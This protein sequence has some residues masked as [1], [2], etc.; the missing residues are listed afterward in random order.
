MDPAVVFSYAPMRRVTARPPPQRP[1][2]MQRQTRSQTSD[3]FRSRVRA[4]LV[5]LSRKY[6]VKP[7]EIA[8]RS[9]VH[10]AT[11][12]RM[13]DP[14]S[15]V[16]PTLDSVHAIASAFNEVMPT[17]DTGA[18]GFHEGDAVPYDAPDDA[19]ALLAPQNAN[20][21]VWTVRNRALE[22]AGYLPGDLVLLD[23]AAAARPGDVVMAQIYD[24]ARGTAE[25]RLRRYDGLFLSVRTLDPALVD[26]R[27]IAADGERAIIMGRIVRMVRTLD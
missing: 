18:I 14:N 8:A 25:T 16:T 1:K 7:P 11:V 9:L 2:P 5:E 19:D 13:L 27:P 24:F 10:K 20:Q 21:S 4:W 12:F 23:Q 22:L 17:G 26:E 3:E 15:K 6:D